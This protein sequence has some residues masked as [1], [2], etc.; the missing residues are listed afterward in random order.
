MVKVDESQ[1]L[2]TVMVGAERYRLAFPSTHSTLIL[3][4][5]VEYILR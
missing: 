5:T 4:S 3:I 1:Q 2:V